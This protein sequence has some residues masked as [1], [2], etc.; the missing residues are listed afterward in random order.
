MKSKVL[1]L[2]AFVFIKIN[3]FTIRKHQAPG[4]GASSKKLA[5]SIIALISMPFHNGIAYVDGAFIGFSW[6][7]QFLKFRTVRTSSKVQI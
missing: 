3:A 4:P 6:E 7:R 5:G 2:P 1:I